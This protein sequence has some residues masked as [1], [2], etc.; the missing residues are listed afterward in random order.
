MTPERSRVVTWSPPTPPSAA[1]SGLEAVQAVAGR[2]L[3]LPPFAVLMGLDFAH[4]E[5]GLVRMT[6]LPGEFHYNP[7]GT[8]HGGVAAT[9]LETVLA[10][11]IRTKLPPERICVTVEIKVSYV[12]AMTAATGE[13]TAE[14]RVVHAGR[15]VALA[16]GRVTD[17]TGRLYA[18]ATST[19]LVT[20]AATG[21]GPSE[22]GER[23]RVVTW[24]DPLENR[25]VLANAPGLA[26]L[27]DRGFGS[28]ISALLGMTMEAVD[29]G[30]VCMSLPPSEHLFSEFNAVH[31]GMMATLLD[32]VMGCAV[33]TTLP[34]GRSFTT[35]DLKMNFLRPITA[36]SGLV[37]AT[38]QVVHGDGPMATAEGRA[39]DAQGQ[40]CATSTTTCLVFDA[41]M[42]A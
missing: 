42:L 34:A 25:R 27:R 28:P 5:P 36:S 38:G 39:V 13:V 2:A 21:A 6:L 23:Q 8:V 29:P 18:T 11:A 9:L 19:C 7:N 1:M 15:Q 24:A 32:S 33:Q 30:M 10:A 3:P 40:L 17:G 20:D 22:T 14:A 26:A 31:G 4:A 35:L 37:T 16:E 41:R 12:R